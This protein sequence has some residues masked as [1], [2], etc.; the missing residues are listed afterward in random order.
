MELG[1]IDIR[2]SRPGLAVCYFYKNSRIQELSLDPTVDA[3]SLSR[4]SPIKM[5]S[6]TLAALACVAYMQ[7]RLTKR[8]HKISTVGI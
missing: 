2:S 4:Q 7:A 3:D 8:R 5:L 1:S 6:L